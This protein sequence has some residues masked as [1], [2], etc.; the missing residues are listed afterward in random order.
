MRF[1]VMKLVVLPAAA[2]CAVLLVSFAFQASEQRPK[3]EQEKKRRQKQTQTA[4]QT[5]TQEAT[6]SYDVIEEGTYSGLREPLVK[7]ITT[8]NEWVELWKRHTALLVPQ[9]P[10]PAVDF[11]THV[12]VAI[13]SGEKKTSGYRI[14]IEN[15]KAEG[16]DVVVQYR[17]TQPPPNSLALQVI[18]Q[19]FVM[20]KIA[21]PK[22]TV[23]VLKK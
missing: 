8:Q 11:E 14:V 6:V 7:L 20:M 9:P 23:R 5:Q 16:A 1:S 3:P 15:V 21:K 10:S 2:V 13:A 19:P 17:E 12:V 18:T 4:P 22:G